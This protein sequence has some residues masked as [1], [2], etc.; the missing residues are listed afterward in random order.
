MADKVD[1]AA[2]RP[3]EGLQARRRT[4]CGKCQAGYDGARWRSLV[5]LEELRHDQLGDILSAWPW[6]LD[7]VLEVRRCRCGQ[8][9]ARLS[10][11]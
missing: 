8:P 11:R 6:Q 10:S 4:T 1:A 9:V 2:V 3:P 7:V 5:L